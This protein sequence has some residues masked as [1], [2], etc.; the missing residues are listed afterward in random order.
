MTENLDPLK[1]THWFYLGGKNFGDSINDWFFSQLTQREYTY[2]KQYKNLKRPHYL[3]TGSILNMV[4]KQSLV[5]GA[6]FIAQDAD[7]GSHTFARPYNNQVFIRP[8]KVYAVRGPKSRQ[9]LLEMGVSCPEV[10]GDPLIL[11]P[12]LYQPTSPVTKRLIGFLPHY[13]DY[14][15]PE[16]MAQVEFHLKY[17]MRK[18]HPVKRLRIEVTR[19]YRKLLDSLAKCEYVVSSTLHG[20]M[21][22][23]VYRKKTVFIQV[24]DRLNGGVFKFQD[25]FESLGIKYTAPQWNDPKLLQHVIPINYGRLQKVGCK[26]LEAAPFLTPEQKELWCHQYQTCFPE[27]LPEPEP[28]EDG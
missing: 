27:K 24:T 23:L 6:G 26:L 12:L 22:G 14:R 20:V 2:T 13:S 8:R 4:A 21:M 9:K 11:F 28:K 1:V 25:F 18:K 5:W 17:G 10:Y 15:K 16:K 3:G 7:L 19:N